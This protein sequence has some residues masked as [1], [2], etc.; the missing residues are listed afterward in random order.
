MANLSWKLAW[1]VHGHAD[2][3][4]LDSYDTERRPHAR[5]V[6]NFALM[7]GR[8]VM[9]SNRLTALGVHGL[10]S[11]A[12]YIPPARAFFEE[13]KI[14]PSARFGRGLFKMGKTRSKLVRGGMLPQGLVRKGIGAPILPSDDALGTRLTLVGFGCD[15]TTRLNPSLLATWQQ[16]GGAIVHLR[17]RG[18]AGTG[19]HSWEDMTDALVPGAAPAGWVAVVRPDR[20]VMHDGPLEELGRIVS[21]SLTLLRTGQPARAELYSAAAEW[22]G[23]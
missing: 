2:K 4:I 9:P 17:H 11:L 15:P 19:V 1:V 20:T 12:Q 13:L 18:Q 6:I 5:S 7:M 8:L 22:Q 23:L 16:A 10:M 14:K 3:S 21:E